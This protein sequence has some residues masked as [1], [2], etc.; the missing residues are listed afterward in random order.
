MENTEISTEF[1]VVEESASSIT[2][3]K[4]GSYTEASSGKTH[5]AE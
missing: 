2:Q 4:K 3:V 1:V 5:F